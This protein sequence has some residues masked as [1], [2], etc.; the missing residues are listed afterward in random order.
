MFN[1]KKITNIF[2]L[3]K[4]KLWSTQ[5]FLKYKKRFKP[6]VKRFIKIENKNSKPTIRLKQIIQLKLINLRILRSKLVFHKQNTLTFIRG[7]KTKRTKVNI[8][9]SNFIKYRLKI[10]LLDLKEIY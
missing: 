4:N 1:L 7:R 10:I 3:S 8:K 9:F 6:K 2:V 5:V